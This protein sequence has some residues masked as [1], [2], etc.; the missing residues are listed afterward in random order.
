MVKYGDP[1][2]AWI[3]VK[4]MLIAPLAP[5]YGTHGYWADLV[6]YQ[7]K[8]TYYKLGRLLATG[9]ITQEQHDQIEKLLRE[10][11]ATHPIEGWS[12]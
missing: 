6:Y 2:P 10:D 9:A 5:Q 1:R 4:T 3:G 8:E 7:G 12:P 11:D